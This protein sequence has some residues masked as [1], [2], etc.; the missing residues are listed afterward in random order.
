VSDPRHLDLRLLTSLEVLLEARNVSRAAERLAVSQPAMSRVLARL[1]D[2]FN[3]PLLVRGRGGMVLTPRGEA[4]REPLRRWLSQGE[5]MLHPPAFEPGELSRTFRVA[6]TDFGVISVI[7]PA[8]SVISE[9]SPG[10]SLAVE[11]L[12]QNSLR[13]LAEG[14]IDVVVTGFRPDGAGLH[15][16]HLFSESHLGLA[17]AGHPAALDNLDLERFLAWPH[18]VAMVGEGFGDGLGE[19]MTRLKDRRVLASSA[20]FSTIPYLV[21][22]SDAL[23]ILPSRAALSYAAVHGHQTFGLPVSPPPFD[24]FVV[25]H[26]RSLEDAPTQW[27]LNLLSDRF[28]TV[29]LHAA[30]RPDSAQ[31]AVMA[32]V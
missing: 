27:L 6:S 11:P 30:G 32:F 28:E 16:R 24:Y 14:R 10:S 26:E 31:S 1:R 5:A 4:L 2:Q 21:A 12:S 7:T 22:A 29:S 23:A 9:T 8:M 19:T 18:V 15:S 25:W 20:S 17:R 3:D 13:L